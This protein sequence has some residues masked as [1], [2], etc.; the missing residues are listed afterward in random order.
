MILIIIS[1]YLRHIIRLSSHTFRI[2][3][4]DK[5]CEV[6]TILDAMHVTLPDKT[7][8]RSFRVPPRKAACSAD[9]RPQDEELSPPYDILIIFRLD[10]RLMISDF[11]ALRAFPRSHTHN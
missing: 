5:Q 3:F 6:R 2:M 9:R 7:R 1:R 11:S 10:A 8:A 4:I